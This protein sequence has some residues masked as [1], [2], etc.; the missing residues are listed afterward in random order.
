MELVQPGVVA[1][2]AEQLLAPRPELGD[3]AIVI[4]VEQAAR[5]VVVDGD[6]EEGLV[7]ALGHLDPGRGHLS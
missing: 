6:A 4:R 2:R 1:E 3:D 7:D 5:A